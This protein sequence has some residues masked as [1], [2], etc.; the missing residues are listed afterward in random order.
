MGLA[1]QRAVLAASGLTP[2]V[3]YTIEGARAASTIAA[4]DG[5]WKSF[6]RWCAEQSPPLVP[7]KA[8]V[9]DVL[10]FLQA[11][12]DEGRAHTTVKVYLASISACLQGVDGKPIGQHALV[13]AFIKGVKRAT[14]TD[15]PLFPVWE[16]AVVLDLHRSS[17]SSLRISGPSA[18]RRSCWLH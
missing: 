2:E 14:A 10:R 3:I 17:L 4:Y 16:L 15:K 1:G 8:P 9:G 12:K 11:R 5:R 6:G 18:S 13:S 7:S